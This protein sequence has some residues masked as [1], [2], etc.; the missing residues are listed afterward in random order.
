ML[1]FA[2]LLGCVPLPFD[3]DYAATLQVVTVVADPPQVDPFAPVELQAWVADPFDRGADVMIW[4]CSPVQL[5]DRVRC[6]EGLD[7]EG[8]GTRL[9]VF[10]RTG[11]AADDHLSVT[12]LPPIQS[13]L[14]LQQLPEDAQRDGVPIP[15]FVLACDPGVCPIFDQVRA[16]PEPGSEAYARAAR[17]LADPEQMADQGP[18]ESVSLALKFYTLAGLETERTSNPLLLPLARR[19]VPDLD[20][21]RWRFLVE[22][23]SPQAQ[24]PLEWRIDV[25]YTSGRIVEQTFREGELEITWS[26]MGDDRGG[27]L[28]VSV[29]DGRGG[30]T[31]ISVP[32]PE[33]VR[34]VPGAP[35]QEDVPEIT[36]QP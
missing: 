6:F 21:V 14:A 26:P 13:V 34:N 35:P 8:K 36:V 33:T 29:A 11:T 7:L 4:P 30:A 12:V 23:A 32:L 5:D 25:R 18:R 22:D 24:R 1:L 17:L 19:L 3:T 9:P 31:A 15:V 10:V 2:G 16:D 27:S 28:I 20:L